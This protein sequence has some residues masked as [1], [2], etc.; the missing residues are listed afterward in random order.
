VS[1]EFFHCSFDPFVFTY[2]TISEDIELSFDQWLDAA[3]AIGLKERDYPLA[4]RTG[5]A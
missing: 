1:Q 3:L 4:S 2:K 5:V